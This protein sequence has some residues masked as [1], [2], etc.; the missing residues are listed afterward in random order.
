MFES[1][2]YFELIE[3]AMIS[4]FFILGIYLFYDDD[5]IIIDKFILLVLSSNDSEKIFISEILHFLYFK[6]D[7]NTIFYSL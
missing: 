2:Y 1:L 5:L 3:S 4:Y 7:V 6:R